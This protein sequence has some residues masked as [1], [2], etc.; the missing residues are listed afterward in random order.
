MDRVVADRIVDSTS[1]TAIGAHHGNVST[2][3]LMSVKSGA[4]IGI[5][6]KNTE[7][8]RRLDENAAS[9]VRP[10]VLTRGWIIMMRR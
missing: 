10:V 1:L 2:G 3:R 8:D 9:S 7:A 6:Q 5:S 4:S